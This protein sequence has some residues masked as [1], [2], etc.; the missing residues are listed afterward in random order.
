MT[1]ELK[2]I[3]K[4]FDDVNEYRKNFEIRKDDRNYHFGDY[5]L[6]KEWD[7]GSYTGREVLRRIDYIYYGDDT[8]GLSKGYV[9]LGLDT[10]AKV[11]NSC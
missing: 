9:I 7:H 2:I 5:L 10:K 11:W 8:Y 6:L 1:H 4:W 3:P